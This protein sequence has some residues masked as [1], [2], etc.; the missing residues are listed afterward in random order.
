MPRGGRALGA[1]IGQPRAAAG[2]L[3]RGAQLF[4]RPGHHTKRRTQDGSAVFFGGQR[5][6]SGAD[7]VGAG[8]GGWAEPDLRR[9]L[10][11]S[12]RGG[13]VGQRYRRHGCALRRRVAGAGHAAGGP[14]GTRHRAGL[15][16]GEPGGH[17]DHRG[18]GFSGPGDGAV[19]L[20]RDFGIGGGTRFANGQVCGLFGHGGLRQVV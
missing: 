18:G 3:R 19:G 9:G 7:V 8:T 5:G 17:G 11:A 2:E 1:R 14:R 10:A 13:A 15:R 16:G 4:R 12:R 20:G 6:G